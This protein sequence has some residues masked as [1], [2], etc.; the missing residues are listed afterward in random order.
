MCFISFHSTFFFL[1]T[2]I[3]SE[4]KKILITPFTERIFLIKSLFILT[5]MISVNLGLINILPIPGLDGGHVFIALIEGFIRREL[6]LKVK[7]AIQLFGFIIIM[8]LF[9]MV[10]FN[11]ISKPLSTAMDNISL[12]T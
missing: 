4:P 8:T 5:A 11:D 2:E 7:Y 9:V 1:F 10:L 12:R 6:P 3:K